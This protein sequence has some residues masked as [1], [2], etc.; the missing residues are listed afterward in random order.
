MSGLRFCTILPAA[1]RA[2]SFEN[3]AALDWS[4]AF[5]EASSVEAIAHA[6]QAARQPDYRELDP[7]SAAIEAAGLVAAARGHAGADLPDGLAAWALERFATSW[8]TGGRGLRRPAGPCGGAARGFLFSFSV[9]WRRWA[10]TG[11]SALR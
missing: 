8:T 9:S 5:L 1:G 3:D 7:A 4:D 2:G 6:L 10:L 11:S